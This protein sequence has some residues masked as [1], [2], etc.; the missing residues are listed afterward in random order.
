MFFRKFLLV[1]FYTISVVVGIFD[2][3]YDFERKTLQ[4]KRIFKIY[5]KIILSVML[6]S[7]PFYFYCMYYIFA[8]QRYTQVILIMWSIEYS[9]L[10]LMTFILFYTAATDKKAIESLINEGIRIFDA[11]RRPN[12]R[13]AEEKSLKFLFIKLF[14]IDHTALILQISVCFAQNLFEGPDA[15][16]LGFLCLLMNFV[17]FFTTNA[18]AFIL[19]LAWWEFEAINRD[20]ASAILHN[21]HLSFLK[22]LQAH[23]QLTAYCQRVVKLF[24]KICITNLLYAFA[25][26]L[27]GVCCKHE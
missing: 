23:R 14:V 3:V 25:T 15:Q 4:V 19:T 13:G 11:S 1:Y 22:V 24:S 5:N 20:M 6:S 7:G 16:I 18:F 12:G 9:T 27:S 26:T 17:S 2:F 21:N 8:H 10:F